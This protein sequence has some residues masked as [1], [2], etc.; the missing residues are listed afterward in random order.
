MSSDAIG[1]SLAGLDV[2]KARI[3]VLSRN[4]SNAQTDGYTD[5]ISSQ[6][7]GLLGQVEL[8]PIQRNVDDQLLQS[9]RET[10][11][12]A[13]QLS[14]SVNL[15]SQIE[16]AFGTPASDSSLSSKITNLQNSLQDLSV[17]PEQ[18]SLYS[19]VLD[20]ANGV[21]RSLNGLSQTVASTSNNA[22]AQLQGAVTTVN[23]TLQGIDAINKQ[24]VAHAG[25][26]DVT[27]E[28]DQ[29][30]RLVQQLGGLLD[31]TTFQ[32][33]DGT[34]AIY[35]KDGKPLVDFSAATL[36]VSGNA[37]DWTSPPSAPSP[38]RISSGTLGGLQTL[39]NTTLPAV[40]AQLDDIARSLTV[41]F[42]AINVPIFNDGGSTPLLGTNP[43]LPIGAGN[44]VDPAQLTGYAGRI[45]VNSTV[46]A[47]P[48]IIRD[49]ASATPL[50]PGDT[51]NIDNAVAIFNKTN[52]GFFASGLPASGSIVQVTTAFV[53]AQSALRANAQ[54]SLDSEN[55]LQ[56]T[57]KNK[58]STQ[59]GVN[60]DNEVA[61]L[62]V[63]QNAYSANARVLQTSKDLFTTLFNAIGP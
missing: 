26:E 8:A 17:N 48:T 54:A 51:T 3:D 63:L 33:P 46:T 27:D 47:T 14:A 60:V 4:I 31:I 38:I 25:N 42:S 18:G 5:K 49:G 16:T 7:T 28:L 57:L 32:R 37:V 24:I 36:A 6:T 44:P 45:A 41:E 20:A 29:R 40:Q 19:S 1:L 12:T 50:A 30:D 59:S 22:Q 56:Q 11:G 58:I 35:T 53:S 2:T 21:A 62:A 61:Q 43:A 13:N 23:S 34:T 52:V 10:T 15:L 9:L 39:Q 55:A